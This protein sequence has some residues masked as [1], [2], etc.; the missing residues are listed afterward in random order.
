MSDTESEGAVSMRD[1]RHTIKAYV[2]ETRE[3]LESNLVRMDGRIDTLSKD[4]RLL[5]D[6]WCVHFDHH[7]VFYVCARWRLH[8]RKLDD[9][10]RVHVFGH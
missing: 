9:L 7:D 5:L 3:Q 8:L 2:G 1:V 4:V 6:V 10:E